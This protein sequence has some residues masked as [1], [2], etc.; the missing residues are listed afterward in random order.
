MNEL[1][2]LKA[3]RILV[4]NIKPVGETNRDNESFENL[5]KLTYIVNELVTDIDDVGYNNCDR[6]EFSMKRSGE[7]ASKF[8]TETLGIV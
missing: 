3:I 8:L 6:Q 2:I 1:E 4:G 5:K 7:F